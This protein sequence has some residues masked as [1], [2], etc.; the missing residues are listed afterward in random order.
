MIWD[1]YIMLNAGAYFGTSFP[2]LV[3]QAY[4]ELVPSQPTEV[5]VPTHPNPTLLLSQP[6]PPSYSEFVPS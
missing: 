4:P 5:S 1:T 6:T 2:H 3:L